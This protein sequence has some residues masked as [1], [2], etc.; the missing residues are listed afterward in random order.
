MF[1]PALSYLTYWRIEPEQ[2]LAIE[3]VAAVRESLYR[4]PAAL[5]NKLYESGETGMGYYVFTVVLRD[6]RRLPYTTGGLVDFPA[7]PSGVTTADIV[8]VDPNVV[9]SRF[10]DRAPLP[11]ESPRTVTWCLY[12]D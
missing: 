9:D 7:L 11:E 2:E 12:A 5:A 3:A 10:H 4:L 1:A 6:G 8:D